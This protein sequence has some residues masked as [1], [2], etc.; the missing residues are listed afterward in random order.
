MLLLVGKCEKVDL[1]VLEMNSSVPEA[2]IAP[3]SLQVLPDESGCL[4]P[5]FSFYRV[6]N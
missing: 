5:G 1:K 3:L 6:Y 4:A 2:A